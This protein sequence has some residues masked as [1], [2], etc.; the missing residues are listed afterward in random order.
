MQKKTST[1]KH[2]DAQG[3]ARQTVGQRCDDDARLKK[4]ARLIVRLI[5]KSAVPDFVTD[6]MMEAIGR[7]AQVKGIYPWRDKDGFEEFDPNRLAELFA[8]SKLL[9][10]NNPHAR[11][12]QALAEILDN[13][14]TPIAL[15]NSTGDFVTEVC[16]PLL[17]NSSATIEKALLLAS[18]ETAETRTAR[19]GKGARRAS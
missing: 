9:S 13:N 2:H 1:N 12:A 14:K 5:D 8:V 18:A 19:S 4:A 7:A 16:T 3:K 10:F 17:D 15:Y 6:A 11:L